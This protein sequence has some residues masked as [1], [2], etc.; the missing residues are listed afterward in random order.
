MQGLKEA[1]KVTFMISGI[2]TLLSSVDAEVAVALSEINYVG[3]SLWKREFSGYLLKQPI[4]IS[5]NTNISFQE[6]KWFKEQ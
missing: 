2:A 3:V 6:L 4:P 5:G 1:R